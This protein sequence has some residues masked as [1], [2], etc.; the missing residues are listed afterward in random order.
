MALQDIIPE[1]QDVK[2]IAEYR[3]RTEIIRQKLVLQ[4]A[5]QMEFL[6]LL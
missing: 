1:D 6:Q 4:E 3:F 2:E 5:V